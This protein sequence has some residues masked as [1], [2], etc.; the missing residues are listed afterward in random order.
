MLEIGAKAKIKLHWK[1]S[2]YDYTKEKTNLILTKL[3][4]KYNIP[5]DKISIQPDFKIL[6]E[7]GKEVG[8]T[9]DIVDNIQEPKFQLK[10]MKDYLS[11]NDI[12][13]YDFELIKT[14]DSEIN[15]KIDYSQYKNYKKYSI[16][17]VKWD[18]FLSYGEDNFFDFT[19][20]KNLVLLNGDPANQSGKTTFAID[21]IH[22]LLF[23]KTNKSSTQ[24]KI[25]NKHIPEATK[26]TVEGSLTIEGETY[27]IKR[28]LTRTSLEKRNSK[29][30]TNQKVSYYKVVG[31]EL[32]ELEDYIEDLQGESSV[33]TNKIIKEAIGNEADFDMIICATS[34]NL[35]ELI[36]KK[37][38]ERGRLLS[39]WIGL[40]PIE[41]KDV[42][43]R[44]HFNE[45]VKPY[46]I[47]NRNGI[48]TEE[49][50]LRIELFEKNNEELRKNIIKYTQ[51][52]SSIN[53]DIEVLEK[54]KETL[55]ES[56]S[57]IDE[58][59]LKIDITTLTN[60]LNNLLKSGALKK[61][62]LEILNKEIEDFGDINFSLDDYEKEKDKSS[63]IDKQMAVI[64]TECINVKNTINHLLTSEKCPTCGRKYDGIDNT[65]KIN[66]LKKSLEDLINKGK[67]LSNDKKVIDDYI[68]EL[69]E[70]EQKNNEKNRKIT[71]KAALEVSIS[72]L[73]EEYVTSFNLKKDYDKNYEAIDKNNRL[74]IEI[75]NTNE[76]IKNK[77]NTKETNDRLIEQDKKSIEVN[78]KNIEECENIIKQINKEN[79][80]LKHWRMYLDMVGKDGISKM[81]LRK[82]LPIINAQI[83]NLLNDVC[84]FTVNVEITDK[85]E[86]MFYLVK[87]GVKSE[88]TSGSGFERTASAL[89]LRSVLGNISTLPKINCLILDEVMGRV[90]KENYDNMKSLC[91]KML[92]NYDFIIQISHLDEIKDWHNHIITVS[93]IN[94]I[95][96]INIIK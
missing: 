93:K 57:K 26:V 47:T 78:D 51:E 73:R 19:K 72:K 22:F 10:L 25:F 74:D 96:K 16:N 30:R 15:S 67:T 42:L 50:K 29:S 23:G 44:K 64:R 27:I 66:E 8:I 43:A 62:E 12:V 88:L 49:M 55:L 60:N 59:V 1:V 14:I 3:S 35:D 83:T 56:K 95:S 71:K 24:D 20:L 41:E 90:A 54:T 69:K 77:R 94:N 33:K 31:Q 91:E 92:A 84:D 21:L 6:D 4:K 70:K 32:E 7:N 2:P 75:N 85:N 38:A 52:N 45:N 28:E 18:N 5:K 68:K 40:I 58:D 79:H 13:D 48:N 89:A 34:S 17:W 81:V 46:L 65:E 86:I 87:D 9:S 82:T 37:D 36:E 80:L 53:K 63:E 11:A 76:R 61:N 39:R